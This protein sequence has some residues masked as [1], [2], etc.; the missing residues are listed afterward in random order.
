MDYLVLPRASTSSARLS[1]T[2]RS[3]GLKRHILL[4]SLNKVRKSKWRR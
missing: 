1:G 2:K 4:I 3:E